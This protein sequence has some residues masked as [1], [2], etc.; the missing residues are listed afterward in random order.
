VWEG[1]R[2]SPADEE[3]P[4]SVLEIVGP[5]KQSREDG[6]LAGILGIVE[7]Q[8]ITLGTEVEGEKGLCAF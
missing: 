4:K 1:P 2:K 8:L 6:L 5:R 3:I 7:G